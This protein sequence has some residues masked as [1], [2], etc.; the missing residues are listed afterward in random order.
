MDSNKEIAHSPTRRRVATTPDPRRDILL[1]ISGNTSTDKAHLEYITQYAFLDDGDIMAALIGNLITLLN[2]SDNKWVFAA[3]G[4]ACS[5]SVF[6]QSKLFIEGKATLAVNLLEQLALA[7]DKIHTGDTP[8]A[9]TLY[10]ALMTL[11]TCLDMLLSNGI[12]KIK[13]P[14]FQQVNDTLTTL[15]RHNWSLLSLN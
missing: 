12:R 15:S 9:N 5:V 8:D 4:Y 1:E 2:H 7:M 6:T 3:I 10:L 14:I 11:N 13:Q